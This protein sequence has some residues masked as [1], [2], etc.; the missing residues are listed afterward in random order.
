MKAF[1]CTQSGSLGCFYDLHLLMKA[2]HGL[3]EAGF[4]VSS[5]RYFNDLSKEHP[6]LQSQ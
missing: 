4:Y 5:R 6:G 2:R 3:T 1:F